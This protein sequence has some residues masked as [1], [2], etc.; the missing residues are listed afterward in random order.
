MD[1]VNGSQTVSIISE[2]IVLP[3]VVQIKVYNITNNIT[4]TPAI[5][6]IFPLITHFYLPTAL[7][8]YLHVMVKQ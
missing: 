8:N 7:G 6:K 1:Q 4:A 5:Q 2:E 3:F